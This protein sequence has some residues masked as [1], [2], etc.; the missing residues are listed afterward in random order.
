MIHDFDFSN[1]NNSQ[2]QKDFIPT[3]KENSIPKSISPGDPG[4]RHNDPRDCPECTDCLAED[5]VDINFVEEIREVNPFGFHLMDYGIKNYFS[6]IRIPVGKGNEEYSIL[7]VRIAGADPESLIYSD[8]SLNS[9]RLSLPILAIS[10]T[11]E[12]Y[13]IKRFSPPIH[14]IY[15]HL[16]CNGKKVESVY[17]PAPYTIQYTLEIWSEHKAQAEYALYSIISKLNPIGSFFLEEPSMGMS[18]EVIVHPKG[19]SDNSDLESNPDSRAEVKR[20][21]NIEVEG[22]LPLPSK[23]ESTVLSKPVTINE[24]IYVDSGISKG[25]SIAVIRDRI[26]K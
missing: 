4:A 18:L 26:R 1:F 17:R 7:N 21:I 2:S 15:R 6:G 25:Q 5:N 12:D 10:R 3:T 14:P 20:S 8:K 19:S 16:K 13:D 22:W 24:G 11:S 9:G 23:V